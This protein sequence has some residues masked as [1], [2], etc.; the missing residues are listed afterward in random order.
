MEEGDTVA[1]KFDIRAAIDRLMTGQDLTI[2]EL[3]DVLDT[4]AQGQT[5]DAQR[6]AFAA[7]LGLAKRRRRSTEPTAS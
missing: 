5:T 3:I 7:C 1:Q 6:G 2:I 4:I